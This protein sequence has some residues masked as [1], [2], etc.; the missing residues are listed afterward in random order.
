MV[1][2]GKSGKKEVKTKSVS[3]TGTPFKAAHIRHM[4]KLKTKARIS[5][6][7]IMAMASALDYLMNEII[8]SAKSAALNDGKKTIKPVYINGAIQKDS[9]L[10]ALGK[11]WVIKSGGFKQTMSKKKNDE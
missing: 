3:P 10:T 5:A 7:A 11:N 9:E 6:T 1:T 2:T 8:E 4:L